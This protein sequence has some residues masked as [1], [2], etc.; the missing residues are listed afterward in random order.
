M[1]VDVR[2]VKLGA[3]ASGQAIWAVDGDEPVDVQSVYATF[4]GAAASGSYVAALTLYSPEGLILWR[5]HATQT[6]AVGDS[7]DVTFA[8]FLEGEAAAGGSGIQFDT[9]PQA[10]TYLWTQTTGG[11]AGVGLSLTNEQDVLITSNTDDVTITAADLMTI[12]GDSKASIGSAN[13]DVVLDAPNAFLRTSSE[14]A[15]LETT[16]AGGSFLIDA[17]GAFQ[18]DGSAGGLLIRNLDSG[19]DI[20]VLSVRNVIFQDDNANPI[21]Q[22]DLNG[23]LHGKTGQALTF[24]L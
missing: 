2:P 8:P 4:N 10:G 9:N 1:A 23:A 12:G 21:F 20:V 24:D 7:A 19:A 6:L 11:L 15:V 14:S 13:G 5:V 3:V 22:I 16:D 17:N 18:L